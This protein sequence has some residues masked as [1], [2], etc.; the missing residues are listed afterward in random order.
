MVQGKRDSKEEVG[1]VTFRVT[2]TGQ[3]AGAEVAQLYVHDGH[4]KVERPEKELKGFSRIMLEP[5]ESKTIS[6]ALDRAALAYWDTKTR[7]WTAEPGSF[8]MLVG[9]SS[10]DVHLSGSFTLNQ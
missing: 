7:S 8:E 9:S 4:S 10:R 6:I 5:G 2:N 1:A 3:R